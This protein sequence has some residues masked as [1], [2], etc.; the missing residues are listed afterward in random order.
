MDANYVD[1]LAFLNAA[2]LAPGWPPDRELLPAPKMTEA[3]A[4]YGPDAGEI[5]LFRNRIAGVKCD[6]WAVVCQLVSL[7]GG[8]SFW[9]AVQVFLD[10]RKPVGLEL[11]T[12]ASLPAVCERDCEDL[13]DAGVEQICGFPPVLKRLPVS[14]WFKESLTKA[15]SDYENCNLVVAHQKSVSSL[16]EGLML[17]LRVRDRSLVE[18]I[19]QTARR[20]KQISGLD[21]ILLLKA[22]LLNVTRNFEVVL[23]LEV[24]DATV[25]Q[26]NAL[27][28]MRTLAFAQQRLNLS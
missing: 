9:S 4:K 12:A 22:V 7:L 24:S 18:A 25:T 1:A 26:Q 2:A 15:N 14:K 16:A 13:F 17:A 5:E 20:A 3:A 6:F 21:C 8:T 19:I 10:G 28:F 23:T 27:V 11:E